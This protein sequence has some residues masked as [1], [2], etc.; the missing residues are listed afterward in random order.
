MDEPDQH[1]YP[2]SRHQRLSLPKRFYL[3]CRW[4]HRHRRRPRQP[5]QPNVQAGRELRMK[6]SGGM[7]EAT[8]LLAALLA[9]ISACGAVEPST[10]PPPLISAV[11]SCTVARPDFGAVASAADR[12]LFGY[13]VNAPLN[14]QK[15]VEST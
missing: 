3:G 8:T 4:R 14:L 5:S 13:D 15:A 10:P 9:V 12:V 11:D 7:V 1:A 6:R 2:C